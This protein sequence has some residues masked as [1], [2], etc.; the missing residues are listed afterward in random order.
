M[1]RVSQL[2]PVPN[3][4]GAYSWLTSKPINR[5]A[6]MMAGWRACGLAILEL[7]SCPLSDRRQP[8]VKVMHHVR[9]MCDESSRR[10]V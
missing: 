3:L 10:D 6:G 1:S 7:M 5:P 8:P 4:S 2:P 9:H